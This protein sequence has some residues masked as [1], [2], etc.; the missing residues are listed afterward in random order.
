MK[1]IKLS[2]ITFAIALLFAVYLNPY[3]FAANF[4]LTTPGSLTVD[5]T[6][7]FNS[8][9]AT[10]HAKDGRGLP[11]WKAKG[12]ADFSDAKWQQA[13]SDWQIADAIRNG[14]GKFM[15]AWKTKLTDN[16]ILSLVARIRAFKKK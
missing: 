9:C 15:P 3:T 6:E 13:H 12:Q 14:K 5:A 8:K 10:C 2:I 4:Y 7:I 16:E 11:N 1:R